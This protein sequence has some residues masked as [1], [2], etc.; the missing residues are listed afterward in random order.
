[1][2]DQVE[3]LWE[4]QQVV[5]QL[6]DCERQLATKPESFA[7]VD[8]EYE[9]A[10]QETQKLQ[11]SLEAIATERRRVDGELS[12]QQE[13]LKKYQGQLMLVKNQQQYAAAWKEIDASR[14][15]VKELEDSVLKSMTESEETQ[16]RLDERLGSF[17]ELKVRYGAEHE[18]W[19]LSLGDLRREAETLRARQETIESSL[20][21]RVKNEF[22]RIARQRG[23]VAVAR[24]EGDTCT[25][26][27][28]HVR[29]AL[30][31]RLRRG[32][33]VNCE[34]CS[35]VLHMERPTS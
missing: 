21:P 33:L 15:H 30:S 5:T 11:E 23:N 8:A 17:E 6:G 13:M 18:T 16:G 27:R 20:P 29:P 3:K 24:V 4:L 7:A 19:Q 32:E 25:A 35:R 10:N 26:C 28:T 9:A 12:D 31:Q 22:W 2:N 34:G 14:K 1:M